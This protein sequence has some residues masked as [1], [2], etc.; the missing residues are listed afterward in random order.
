[1]EQC[2]ADSGLNSA[3]VLG[4]GLAL[5][6]MAFSIWQCYGKHVWLPRLVRWATTGK[7]WLNGRF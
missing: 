6:L 7:A 4:A 1:M 3:M 2:T 5:T